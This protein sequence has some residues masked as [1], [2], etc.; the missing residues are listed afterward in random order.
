MARE[1]TQRV[2]AHGRA[3]TQA[4]EANRLMRQTVTPGRTGSA[5]G[6]IE[7]EAPAFDRQ[8]PTVEG[9]E[10]MPVGIWQPR[11]FEPEAPD[12]HHASGG[13]RSSMP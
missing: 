4:D 13:R 7:R 11:G 12:E 8:P 1:K 5:A 3:G 2:V 9:H 10:P 6:A